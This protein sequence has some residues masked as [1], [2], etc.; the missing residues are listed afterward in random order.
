MSEGQGVE[1]AEVKRINSL[2]SIS[3]D[4]DVDGLNSAAIVWRYAMSKG[5][6]F[7]VNLTDYG[8]FEQVFSGVASRRETLIVITDLGMDETTQEVVI[9]GLSR[10]ISQGC[11][12]VWLDHHQWS[13]KSIKAILSLPNNPVLKINHDYCA[14]EIAQKVLM[15]R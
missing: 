14:A 7:S 13:E 1:S 12:V 5:L 11:R 4:K 8:A 3:H 15:P 2:L 10:A 6:Q 9:K